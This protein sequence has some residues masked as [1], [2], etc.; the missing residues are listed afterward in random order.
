M[1][2]RKSVLQTVESQSEGQLLQSTTQKI[3]TANTTQTLKVTAPIGRGDVV[4]YSVT[5]SGLSFNDIINHFFTTAI[6]GK[7]TQQG[8]PAIRFA[9]RPEVNGFSQRI[10]VHILIPEGS[11][12][13][14]TVVSGAI[15]GEASVVLDL[16]FTDSFMPI[17]FPIDY[18]ERFSLTIPAGSAGISE[19]FPIP[20]KRGHIV[21]LSLTPVNGIANFI[22]TTIRVSVE[23]NGVSLIEDAAIVR[24]LPYQD[25]PRINNWIVNIKGGGIL[26]LSSGGSGALLPINHEVILYFSESVSKNYVD[27]REA[28]PILGR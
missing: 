7:D 22:D 9:N 18:S 5:F 1:T 12:I 17:T 28:S 4:A 11:R 16:Y 21:G 6:N 25:T 26:K 8:L 14:V 2:Q 20:K 19:T 3:L 10:K 24:Y 15:G 13:D 23:I 27:K